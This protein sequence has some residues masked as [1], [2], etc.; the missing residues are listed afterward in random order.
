LEQETAAH[1]IITKTNNR[2]TVFIRIKFKV[3]NLFIQ[4]Y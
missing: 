3:K 1:E 4:T 2:L